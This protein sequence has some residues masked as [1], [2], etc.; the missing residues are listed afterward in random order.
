MLQCHLE[1]GVEKTCELLKRHKF[2]SPNYLNFN[3][4]IGYKFHPI[5]GVRGRSLSYYTRF[6]KYLVYYN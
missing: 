6:I 2:K 5:P 3:W 1:G 4:P